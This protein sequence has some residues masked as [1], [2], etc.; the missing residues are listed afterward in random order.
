MYLPFNGTCPL[1]DRNQ[2]SQK[3]S[4]GPSLFHPLLSHTHTHTCLHS[5]VCL[6]KTPGRITLKSSLAQCQGH[7]YTAHLGRTRTSGESHLERRQENKSKAPEVICTYYEILS[8][9]RPPLQMKAY[10]GLL[11]SHRSA[12]ACTCLSLSSWTAYHAGMGGFSSFFTF[13]DLIVLLFPPVLNTMP[14]CFNSVFLL[15]FI[16]DLITTKYS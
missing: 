12:S 9:R 3:W 13:S 4:S 6:F 2:Q 15:C 7:C 10:C 14:R 1:M 8:E 11:T 16:C 5:Q